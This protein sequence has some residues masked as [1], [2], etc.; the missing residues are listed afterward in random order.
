MKQIKYLFILLISFPIYSQKDPLKEERHEVINALYKNLD[1]VQ[2]GKAELD[3]NFYIFFTIELIIRDSDLVD[4][5]FGHCAD[6]ENKNYKDYQFSKLLSKDDISKMEGQIHTM[7]DYKSLDSTLISDK[8]ILV[9]NLDNN[10]PAVTLPLIYND[11]AIVFRTNRDNEETL[12][13][14]V[15]IDDEWIVRC[16]KYLYLRFDD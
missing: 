4:N 13:V 6:F 9:N 7:S 11:K 15:K 16:R 14:L 8:I 2:Y 3:M 12:F 5:S 10:K 1:A